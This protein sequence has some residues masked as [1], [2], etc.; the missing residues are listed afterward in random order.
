MHGVLYTFRCTLYF[1]MYFVISH[2]KVQSTS[3]GANIGIN[4]FPKGNEKR[5]QSISE[6][7]FMYFGMDVVL[8]DVLCRDFRECMY[9]GTNVSTHTNN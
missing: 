9:S 1:W 3:E 5:V 6:S 2:L 4:M 7:T 8:L